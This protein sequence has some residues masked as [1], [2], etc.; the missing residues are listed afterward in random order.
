[1]CGICGF[2]FRDKGLLKKMSKATVHRGPDDYGEYGDRFVSIGQN[3]L[4]IID[5]KKGLYP[6]HNEKD[7][8]QL[9]YNGEIYNFKEIREELENKGHKFYSNCDGEVIVHSY[10]EYGVDCLKKFN[11]MFAICIYDTAKRQLFL[12]RDR[13]GIKPLYYYI[14]AGVFIFCSEIKGI[15]EHPIEREINKPVLDKFIAMRYIP[16]NETIFKNIFSFPPAH[17]GIFDLKKK[18]LIIKEY[19][20]I[21][22]ASVESDED[23][24][25]EELR[26][27]LKDSIK[28]RLISDVPLGVYLSGGIDSSAVVGLLASIK[29]EEDDSSPIK[30]F[31]VGFKYGEG[32]VNELDKAKIVSE[33]YNTEHKEFVI[34]PDISK[35]LPD[36]IKHFDQ[37]FADPAAIPVYEL[38]REATKHVTVVLTGDGGDELFAGYDQYKFLMMKKKLDKIPLMRK[39]FPLAVEKTPKKILDKVYKYASNMGEEGRNRI[40]S[41]MKTDDDLEAY[42]KLISIFYEKEREGLYSEKLKVGNIC[43]GMYETFDKFDNLLNKYCY[44]DVKFLLPDCYLP[45][46]DRTTMAHS[47]EGR[48]PL[49]DHRIAE[50]AFRIPTNLKLHKGTTKYIL[51]KAANKYI[52]KELLNLKKQTFHVPI[53]YW[54]EKELKEQFEQILSKEEL[55]KHG[56]FNH[57]YIQKIFDKYKRSKLVY[58]RQLWNLVN[59]QLWYNIYIDKKKG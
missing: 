40:T 1:M 48:V 49:L 24:F 44:L 35:I 12:A 56:F 17:Y 19:W 52:P 13:I 25:I 50:L 58:A 55:K 16:G 10:E 33:S 18:E 43:N 27:L 4:S 5:L 11:G 9:I 57:D 39:V 7:S 59:F 26:S 28:K 42:Y 53:G 22:E 45:K 2:N 38:S 31:S 36:L 21:E 29:K 32:Y 47:I 54:I 37:P 3:R 8:L 14:K 51:K 20:D 41:F 30:T 34:D 46:T 15:L 23:F 6:M